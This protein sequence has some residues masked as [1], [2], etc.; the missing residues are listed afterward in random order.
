M[1][2]HLRLACSFKKRYADMTAILDRAQT[3]L[4]E[5]NT[6]IE[7]LKLKVSLVTELILHGEEMKNAFIHDKKSHRLL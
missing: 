4:K 6:E 5:K 3:E 7:Q 2:K 1:L